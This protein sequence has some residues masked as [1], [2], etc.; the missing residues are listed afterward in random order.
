MDTSPTGVGPRTS[1]RWSLIAGGYA[2]ACALFTATALSTI[3]DLFAEVIGLPSAFAVPLLAAPAL[4]VGAGV[5]WALVER[6]GRVTYPRG[7]AFGLLTALITAAL[8]TARF[9]SVWSVKLLTADV[10]PLLVGIVVGSAAVAGVLVGLPLT[11]VR[12]RS[13]AGADDTATANSL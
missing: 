10:V 13:R 7:A 4:A 1:R 3:L 12:R 2:F 9:V 8:W 11:Y 6:Q 5:W